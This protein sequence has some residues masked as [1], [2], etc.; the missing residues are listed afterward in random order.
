MKYKKIV[1]FPSYQFTSHDRSALDAF[2]AF[3]ADTSIQLEDVDGSLIAKLQEVDIAQVKK[4]ANEL[5]T[6]ASAG[7]FAGV[8]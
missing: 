6:L 8:I 7:L 5:S 2:N 4:N 1:A 3:F